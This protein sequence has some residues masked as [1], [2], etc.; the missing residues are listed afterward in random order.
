MTIPSWQ[1]G[2]PIPVDDSYE[3]IRLSHGEGARASRQL[4][5]DVIQ[6]RLQCRTVT[7]D[8]ALVQVPTGRIAVATD[9]H[10]VTPLFFPGGNIGSLSVY[11]TINDLAVAGS[12][13]KWLTLGLI[14]EE[15]LPIVILENILDSIASAAEECHVKI[16]A[17][18]T[19]VV[20]R[21][22]ADGLFTNTT[23]VGELRD[24]VP[25]GPHAIQENDCIIVSGPIGQHGVAVMCARDDFSFENAPVSDSASV[26]D[27]VTALLDTVGPAVRCIRDATRG[28]V[29]AVLHEWGADVSRTFQLNDVDI[30]V[31]SRVRGT[32]EL[33]G[34]DPLYVAN[35]GTFVTVVSR[36]SAVAALESLRS[37]PVSA[38]AAIIGTVAARGICPVTVQRSLGTPQPLDEPSGAPLPRIC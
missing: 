25:L 13:P 3:R 20:P 6:P 9:S 12:V 17:G 4:I 31:D 14:I 27:G 18:D 2:C 19:K 22:A 26:A 35:E 10:T 1:I 38:R 34:L 33:L 21:G 5:Q 36:E 24:V 29:S 37:V 23:G 28:G 30:P 7:E 32:C 16:I 8:A 11:G 15:G